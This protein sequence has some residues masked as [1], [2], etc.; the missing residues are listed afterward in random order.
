MKVTSPVSASLARSPA[1]SA[2]DVDSAFVTTAST[3]VSSSG[4]AA[5]SRRSGHGKDSIHWRIG[6]LGNTR[7]TSPAA[8]STMRRAP[9][10]GQN[11]RLC[12]V[13]EYA[14]SA[15][16]KVVSGWD[17]KALTVADVAVCLAYSSPSERGD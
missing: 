15:V 9:Q 4:R 10:D 3:R 7:S 11:P 2:S 14:E 1:R 13:Q 16:A 12:E 8:L 6:T 17:R 5:K